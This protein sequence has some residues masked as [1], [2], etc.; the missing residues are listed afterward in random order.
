MCNCSNFVESDD[1]LVEE[2]STFNF[3]GDGG[4]SS[5]D[6]GDMEE[7][8]NFLT[9][10]MRERRRVKKELRA[11]GL[12]RKEARQKALELVPRD[13]LKDIIAKLRSG[14][15]V[16]VEGIELGQ[17]SLGD[18]QTALKTAQVDIDDSGNGGKEDEAG[19]FDKN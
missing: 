8:D 4:Q 9:K 5:L 7:F 2:E 16:S 14:E 13:K 15:S 10:K 19:F 17:E 12:S 18:V 6:F 3:S 11:G 1:F